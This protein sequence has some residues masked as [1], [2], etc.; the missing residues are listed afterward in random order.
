MNI[1]KAKLCPRILSPV[2][3]TNR[4]SKLNT[5]YKRPYSK[6]YNKQNY[7]NQIEINVNFQPIFIPLQLLTPG[8]YRSQS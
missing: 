8:Y 7:S 2:Y 6:N 1:K 4:I 5:I 3:I